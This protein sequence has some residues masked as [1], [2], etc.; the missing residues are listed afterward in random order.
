MRLT[1]I[2]STAKQTGYLIIKVLGLGTKDVQTVYNIQP[3]GI[4]SNPN[5]NIRGIWAKTDNL[6]E[7]I[8]IGILFNRPVS[9]P[10]ELRLYS[11]DS[12]GSE[13]IAIYLKNDGSIEL[14][15]G[16][17]YLTKYNELKLAFDKLKDD[18]N[19]HIQ[20]Y[21]AHVHPGVL[22]GGASTLVTTTLSSQTTA[23][24]T[25]SKSNILKTA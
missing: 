8:L 5:K 19:S 20:N 1:K 11:E 23:D 25:G 7:R 18:V 3:F 17:N 2:I 24:M 14:G 6:E 16:T 12:N 9:S 21:N 4:D 13:K 10:G 15:G 22:S